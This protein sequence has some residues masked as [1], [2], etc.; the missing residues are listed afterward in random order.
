MFPDHPFFLPRL[1]FSEKTDPFEKILQ[2]GDP[3]FPRLVRPRYEKQGL[4]KSGLTLTR[5]H[6]EVGQ[7]DINLKI[8]DD[9]VMIHLC[10]PVTDEYCR[11]G[12]QHG[13]L[14]GLRFP[15]GSA[16][17]FTW[18]STKPKPTQSMVPNKIGIM[19]STGSSV[20]IPKKN[21]SKR[22]L[23]GVFLL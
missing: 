17:F 15:S 22:Q 7:E 4:L 5:D 19:P 23:A 2:G 20:A 6:D 3:G 1:Q 9:D 12:R 8:E 21:E 14:G 16:S 13:T 18:P 11:Y 10:F